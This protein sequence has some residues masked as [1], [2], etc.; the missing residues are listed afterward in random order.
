MNEKA[1]RQL[2]IVNTGKFNFDFYWE[3]KFS[4]RKPKAQ[5]EIVS[6]TPD[7]GTV[8]LNTRK[9]CVLAFCPNTRFSL[10]GADLILKV[11]TSCVTSLTDFYISTTTYLLVLVI[12]LRLV[13]FGH[14]HEFRPNRP[15]ED[16]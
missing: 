3:W 16:Q 4:G 7:S 12:G 5:S 1:T 10:Q 9:R 8:P 2:Y 15:N 6:I 13:R 11:G 14:E